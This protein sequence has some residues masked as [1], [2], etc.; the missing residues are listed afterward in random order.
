MAE[1][2]AN[3]LACN[4]RCCLFLTGTSV[5]DPNRQAQ[6][7][8]EAETGADMQ[9]QG[10]CRTESR[11]P[12]VDFAPSMATLMGVPIPFGSIG[13]ISRPL[14]DVAHSMGSTG[15]T[16][17]SADAEDD[18]LQQAAY[19][20]ALRKN[21]AQVAGCMVTLSIYSCTS[22]SLGADLLHADYLCRDYASPEH[23]LA[24]GTHIL[25]HICSRQ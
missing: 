20:Q 7:R 16:S 23:M 1:V 18:E 4:N 6:T 2:K 5:V 12:Q 8:H 19:T 13:Q 3:S 10:S 25:E 14:W 21:A 15:T 22:F 17:C 9:N 24:A 11:T